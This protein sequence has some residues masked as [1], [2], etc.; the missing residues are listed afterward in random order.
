MPLRQIGAVDA[1]DFRRGDEIFVMVAPREHH[2]CGD[3]ADKSRGDHPPDVPDQG[4][5]H[6][7]GEERAH[8]SGRRI[9]GYFDVLSGN[10]GNDEIHGGDVTPNNGG[11]GDFIHGGPGNDTLDGGGGFDFVDYSGAPAG[12]TVDLGPT[13]PQNT[14]GAGTDT[15]SNFEGI[16]GW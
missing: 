11:A 15:L 3:R 5:A 16:I 2:E 4:K 14:T 6:H 10:G 8:K 9:A 1:C 12:V 7:G 13:S